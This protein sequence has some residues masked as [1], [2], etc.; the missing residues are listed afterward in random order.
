M[1]RK[2]RNAHTH[3]GT[4]RPASAASLPLTLL[5]YVLAVAFGSLMPLTPAESWAHVWDALQAG[6]TLQV[7]QPVWAT[8]AERVLTF[9]PMGA[10]AGL[11]MQRLGVRRPLISAASF[12]ILVALAIEIAQATVVGRHPRLSDFI[13]AALFGCAGSASSRALM[14]AIGSSCR[15]WGNHPIGSRAMVSSRNAPFWVLVFAV[16]LCNVTVIGIL[17]VTHSGVRIAGWNCSYPLLVGNELTQDRPWLGRIRGVAIYDR[18]PNDAELRELSHLP[19]TAETS[20]VRRRAGALLVYA[21]DTVGAPRV[22][23]LGLIT[24][25]NDLEATISGPSIGTAS[26]GA[27]DVDGHHLVRSSGV[28]KDLCER[29][30]RSKAFAVEADIASGDLSQGGPARIVSMSLD[31][32]ERNF[33]LGQDQGALIFRVRTPRNGP[34]GLRLPIQTGSHA[35]TGAWQHVWASYGTGRAEILIDGEP[36]MVTSDGYK[37]LVLDEERPPVPISQIA[38]L[39]YFAGG[40]ISALLFAERRLVS[41]LLLAYLSATAVPTLFAFTL[42]AWYG[43]DLDWVLLAAAIVSPGLGTIA[44][45][46]LVR[47]FEQPL[48]TAT[49]HPAAETDARP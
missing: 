15:W 35:I 42:E 48:S 49:S 7:H 45:R 10:L 5:L 36:A 4:F 30:M 39:L 1:G 26:D 41:T 46:V 27:L 32:L 18:V 11:Q 9:L 20:E 13:L 23:N 28:P 12:I 8:I 3:V 47:R 17:T 38:T 34:N 19:M 44:G 24:A 33:T 6:W 37:M 14:L 22:P 21:F 29:I 40:A 16:V 31:T 43:Y 2:H 25:N